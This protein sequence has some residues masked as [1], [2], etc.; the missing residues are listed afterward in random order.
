[1]LQ[2]VISSAKA[3]PY[4]LVGG[5]GAVLLF[6]QLRKGKSSA[7]SSGPAI[8]A[9]TQ[10]PNVIAANAAVTQSQLAAGVATHNTDAALQLGLAQISAA[11]DIGSQQI[12]AAKD[13]ATLQANDTLAA[14]QGQTQAA[15]AIS[16]QKNA[17]D[18][19][20]ANLQAQ[21]AHDQLRSQVVKSVTDQFNSTA[22][23]QNTYYAR[24]ITY[25]LPGAIQTALNSAGIA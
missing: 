19:A 13:V 23:G 17:S 5:V 8:Y 6:L 7:S 11:H 1:M 15:I 10:D 4:I 24:E 16:A 12:T 3:H 20:V 2:S 14:T 21:T 18:T 22:A 9:F 25:N